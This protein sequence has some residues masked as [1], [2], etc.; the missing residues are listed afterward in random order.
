MRRKTDFDDPIIDSSYFAVLEM[1]NY[2]PLSDLS[3]S[4]HTFCSIHPTQVICGK[5]AQTPNSKAGSPYQDNTAG[6]GGGGS[7][8]GK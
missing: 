7:H 4:L 3:T 2:G 5:P 1:L 8:D 6:G